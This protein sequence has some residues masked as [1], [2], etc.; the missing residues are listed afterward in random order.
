LL[1][2]VL[3][4]A[5]CA[6]TGNAN[7][8]NQELIDQIQMGKSTKNDVRRLLGEP[9]GISRSS[10]Q[11]ANP[12]D[13]KLMLTLVEWWSY[14]HASSE[15]DAASFIPFV[16]MFVGSTTHESTQFTAGFD[17][18]GIVQHITSGSYKGK[19]GFMGSQ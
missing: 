1:I 8:K 14:I 2:V 13:P 19:S 15:T 7:V 4:L 5:G 17:Q 16:G 18:K 3:S 10:S 11:V 6:S 12:A 9:N